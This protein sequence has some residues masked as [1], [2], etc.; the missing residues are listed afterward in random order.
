MTIQ[1]AADKWS[2]TPGTIFNYIKQGRIPGVQRI[3]QPNKRWE[4]FIPDDAE[5][6]MPKKPGPPKAE[7]QLVR[8]PGAKFPSGMSKVPKAE[9]GHLTE[10]D[11]A[12]F[13]AAHAGDMTYEELTQAL[14]LPR[15]RIRQIYDQLHDAYGI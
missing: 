5:K 9:P 3:A 12:D 1:Q 4:W 8:T 13:I 10:Q 7:L 2:Y 6:P 15:D 14:R 11:I